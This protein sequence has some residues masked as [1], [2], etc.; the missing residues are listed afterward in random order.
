MRIIFQSVDGIPV[1]CFINVIYFWQEFK[2][3]IIDK[4]SKPREGLWH[5]ITSKI[6]PTI[7]D[8]NKVGMLYA[9]TESY[10]KQEK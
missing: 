4:R 3:F 9:V 6:A 5:P 7:F 8:T 10:A 1:S 2:L